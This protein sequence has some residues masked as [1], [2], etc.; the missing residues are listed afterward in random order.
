MEEEKQLYGRTTEK[1]ILEEHYRSK[2]SSLIAI[3][4]RRRIGKTYLVRRSLENKIDFECI[5]TQNGTLKEQLQNFHF[6]LAER[7]NVKAET[8]PP[9]NWIEA[10]QMLKKYLLAKKGKQKKV[11]FLDEFPWMNSAKSG[12][13]EKFAHFWNSWASEN[14][15]M[16]I[17][18]GSAATWMIK[19]VVNGKGGLHNRISQTIHLKPFQLSQNKEMLNGMGI[20]A[21]D[22]QLAE[23]YM[24]FGGVP[25]Y[26]SL[27]KKSKST[28]Q[29][30]DTLL[31]QENGKLTNEYE[32]LLPSLFD[33]PTNHIA[34]LEA[35]ALKWKGLSRAELAAI[36]KNADGG[37]LT[38]IL[39]DLA[40]SGFITS[41]LPFRKAKKETL[42]RISDSFILFYLKFLKR[43]KK[44][45]FIDIA[46][47][48]NYRTWCG[49][50]FENLCLQHVNKVQE[51][52]GLAKIKTYSS[53]YINKG[54][55]HE[56]GFQFDLL[57][58]RADG[59]INICEMKYYN[60]YFAIDKA[61]YQKTRGNLA[62]FQ[63]I[64]GNKYVLRYTIIT[65][66]GCLQNAYYQELVDEDIQLKQLM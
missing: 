46:K 65:A 57:I 28:H 1:E 12:F 62:K 29:N 49:F 8:T 27:F 54:S 22:T 21:T 10:F 51:S 42:Y 9:Q 35:M 39:A 45:S 53:S 60:S 11:I 3:I 52:L 59:V 37:G 2:Q 38:Q 30:I 33:N 6:A 58:E 34:V 50:A 5:G 61:M 14:N 25:Y 55:K 13:V 26:L 63:T 47:T 16:I 36:Y 19:H 32:N 20:K 23:L 17:L 44:G 56:N 4:G 40:Y 41:Y 31:Y 24:V 66:N 15:V 48:A 43:N 7:F 64:A 18:C